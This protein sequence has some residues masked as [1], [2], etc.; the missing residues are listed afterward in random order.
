MTAAAPARTHSLVI[1]LPEGVDFA[2]P[3]AGPLMRVI[4]ACL[5]MVA[6]VLL[7]RWQLAPHLQGRGLVLLACEIAVG[8]VLY[9]SC[10]SLFG[11]ALLQDVVRLLSASGKSELQQVA[12][13]FQPAKATHD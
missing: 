9:V 1:R 2:L 10:M 6:G 5:V 11:R 12:T 3:L 8:A 4:A 7:L 13:A